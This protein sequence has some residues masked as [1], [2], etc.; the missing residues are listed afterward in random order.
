[1]FG[2]FE[3]SWRAD[4]ALAAGGILRDSGYH[5][6]DT[7]LTVL[8]QYD[9]AAISRVH[10]LAHAASTAADAY[11]SVL[12][13]A[14]GTVCHVEAIRGA[15][16]AL[17]H[18]EYRFFGDAGFAG[19]NYFTDARKLCRVRYAS[20]RGPIEDRILMMTSSYVHHPLQLFC[21][22]VLGDHDSRPNVPR[23][24]SPNSV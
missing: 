11:T 4:S 12:F 24:R 2:D 3:A 16:Q 10:A 18:E 20:P 5:L 19:V 23:S 9:A 17:K 6:I 15:P 14:S 22:A 21:Q 8:G 13:A 7:V 1:M